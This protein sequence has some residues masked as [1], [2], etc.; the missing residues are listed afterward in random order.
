[1]VVRKIET[2]DMNSQG[3]LLSIIESLVCFCIA[4][5][6]SIDKTDTVQLLI[7]TRVY[8]WFLNLWRTI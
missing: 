6:E 4:L 7:F 1:M 8:L 3:Q 5:D 2:M